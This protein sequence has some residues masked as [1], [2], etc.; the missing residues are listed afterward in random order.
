MVLDALT[1]SLDKELALCSNI[2][3]VFSNLSKPL[4]T[5]NIEVPLL[6]A[7]DESQSALLGSLGT[8]EH[9]LRSFEADDSDR[10]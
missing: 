5:V 9:L 6:I 2:L 4:L 8:E 3:V 7:F 1:I 10:E